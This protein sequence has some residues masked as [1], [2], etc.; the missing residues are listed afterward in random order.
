[1]FEIEYREEVLG[2]DLPVIPENLQHRIVRAIE[3]RLTSEPEK[4]G[5]RLRRSLAGLWKLRVGDYRV[6]FEIQPKRVRI[7][8]IVHRKRAYEEAARRWPPS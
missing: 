5:T 2:E 3:A 1:L 4:Y 7:W 6:V 8:A